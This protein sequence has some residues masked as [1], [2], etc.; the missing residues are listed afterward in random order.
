VV[1][2]TSVLAIALIAAAAGD[3]H[4]APPTDAEILGGESGWRVDDVEL[5]TAYLA[6][7]GHGFQSQDGSLTG[8]GSEWMWLVEPWARVTLH[9]NDRVTHE[10][11]IP[12]DVIT[13]A[14]PDAVDATTSASRVNKSVDVDVRSTIEVSEHDT[15]STRASAHY[16]EPLSSGTL[17]AGW[18]RSVA[19]DNAVL[20]ASANVTVDGFDDRDHYGDY[21]GKTAR[22]TVNANVTAS[23]LLSPTTVIDGGYGVT[24]QHGTLNTGWNSVPISGGTLTNE[25]LP[26]DRVRH[27]VTARLAQHVPWTHSTLKAWYRFYLDDFGLRAHS[28]ELAAYQ[29]LVPWLYV[30]GSYRYH[31][32][33]GV[34]FF[35]TML[36]PKFDLLAPRTADSDLAPFAAHEWSVQ[37]AIVRARA[38]AALGRWSLGAEVMRYWRTN[39]LQI[40]VVALSLGRQ[41]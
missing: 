26:R 40:T 1:A 18:R 20:G 23:Q 29:Y 25:V 19:D 3:G 30:R 21:L 15:L 5:R 24:Y 11:T 12:V 8:P 4:A 34:D 16:E 39:D 9:Q 38:P 41:L 33:T 10:I 28:I 6:Q 17:G 36:A 7:R 35:T 22:E 32:Q 13:A 2:R 27:A 31:H 37:L 14:S